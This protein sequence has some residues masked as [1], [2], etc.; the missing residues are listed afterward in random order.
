MKTYGPRTLKD[1]DIAV[2][3]QQQQKSAALAQLAYMEDVLQKRKVIIAIRPRLY[4][5]LRSMIAIGRELLNR[6]EC[7]KPYLK[8]LHKYGYRFYNQEHD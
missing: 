3:Y 6:H 7:N 5:V 1:E 4:E 8:V 2:T